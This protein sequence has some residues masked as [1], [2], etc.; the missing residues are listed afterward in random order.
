MSAYLQEA[1]LGNPRDR[2]GLPAV[3][4]HNLQLVVNTVAAAV[5]PRPPPPT[6]PAQLKA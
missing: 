4:G 5:L 2:A 3:R 1:D 6:P